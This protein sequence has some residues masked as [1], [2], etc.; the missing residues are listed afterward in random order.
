MR[1]KKAR[2]VLCF[3]VLCLLIILG[4][5]GH[6]FAA[7]T[8]TELQTLIN[9]T[10]VG[11]TLDINQDYE[12]V[13]ADAAVISSDG[14]LI[15]KA[16]V[17][18]AHG[19]TVSAAGNM[20]VFLIDGV[21]GSAVLTIKNIRITEGGKVASG[22]AISIAESNNVNFDKCIITK[23]GTVS[24]THT[25][26]G[27][28]I[29]ID[30]K[31]AVEFKD[32]EISGNLGADRAAGVYIRGN[33]K[34]EGCTIKDNLG[35]SRAGGIY[36][37]P[38]YQAPKRGGEWGGN[39]VMKNCTITGN[40]AGRGA[41]IYVNSENEKLNIFEDCLFENNKTVRSPGNGGGI[42]FYNAHARMTN[43]AII[44][45]EADKGSGVLIDVQTDV[46]LENCTITGNKATGAFG[47]GLL[48]H[49]G[50]YPTD[51][52]KPAGKVRILNSTI[53][54]NVASGDVKDDIYI[55]WSPNDDKST[56]VSLGPWISRYDGMITSGGKNQIGVLVNPKNFIKST[57]D[58]IDTTKANLPKGHPDE[59]FL[60]PDGGCNAGFGFAVLLLAGIIAIR[61]P[62]RKPE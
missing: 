29:F 46:T 58:K 7:G 45:N 10:P 12:F 36:V 48:C 25:A 14:I 54:L 31:A 40:T 24:G 53:I 2:N 44:D 28:A 52:M 49:D 62:L 47:G 43:C 56:D 3:L 38:G 34:F 6:A 5:G 13:S 51:T 8:F 37:D 26:D 17:L 57:S 30:S 19:H 9:A 1:F 32:C 20:R 27:G 11:G 59:N 22:S 41:G 4:I 23:N 18:D 16:I 35:S 55:N 61:K 42:L 21:T 15:S 33:V 50:S 60:T 39:V